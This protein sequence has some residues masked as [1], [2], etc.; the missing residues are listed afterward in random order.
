M[1]KRRKSKRASVRETRER[2]GERERLRQ[3][4]DVWMS[5]QP[6]Q[7]GKTLCYETLKNFFVNQ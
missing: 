3:K 5:N 7:G 1:T 4:L 2:E 6:A